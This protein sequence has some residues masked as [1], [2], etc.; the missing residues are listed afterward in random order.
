MYRIGNR[1]FFNIN[2]EVEYLGRSDREIKLRG[3]RIDLDD[4][5]IR[6]PGAVEGVT[7][8]A[9]CRCGDCLFC[10]LQPE[11]LGVAVVRVM[12]RKIMP[13]YAVPRCFVAVDKFPMTPAGKTDYK[14]IASMCSNNSAETEAPRQMQ[15]SP[16]Q[17][18]LERVWRE[19]LGLPADIEINVASNFMALGGHSVMQLQLSSRL[20]RMHG[21]SNPLPLVIGSATLGELAAAIDD[22]K[23]EQHGVVTSHGLVPLGNNSASPIEKDWFV[24]YDLGVKGTCSFNVSYACAIDV[25]Q[26]DTECLVR[27]WNVILCRHRIFRSRSIACPET[28]K[29]IRRLMTSHAP[30]VTKVD[31]GK[32]FSLWREVNRPISLDRHENLIRV[33]ASKTHMLVVVSH[34]LA[35]LTM[36][37]IILD[38]LIS[39]YNGAILSPVKR[40]YEQTMQWSKTITSTQMEWWRLTSKGLF[41][42]TAS[43]IPCN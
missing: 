2:G 34:I 40:T 8:V 7:A 19:T 10:M 27:A 6:I 31:S 17:L 4:L 37:Q 3:Y 32:N 42:I 38:E 11:T 5:K 30:Q 14:E 16:S 1:G 23:S 43:L 24:K 28:N 12:A 39:V 26:V 25:N 22:R 13:A 21:I 9:I 41:G 35:A 15:M 33:F 36:L 18:A 20:A 29:H